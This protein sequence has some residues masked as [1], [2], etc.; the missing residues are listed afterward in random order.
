MKTSGIKV[1]IFNSDYNLLGDNP[2]EVERYA[3][4]V[5]QIMQ[6]IN[7]QSPNTSVESVAVV[8]ALN[9]AESYYREKDLR[10]ETQ[11]EYF[12]TMKSNIS[13]I[14]EI[15]KLIDNSL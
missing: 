3:K 11:K 2:A 5:D 7:F 8:S 10:Y 14:E 13:K 4:Y 1:K 15:T 9:I 6:R 12:D